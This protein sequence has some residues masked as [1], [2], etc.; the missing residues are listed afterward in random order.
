MGDYGGMGGAS[1]FHAARQR[2]LGALST[3]KSYEF[4]MSWFIGL[5]L[6][7]VV[8]VV[9]AGYLAGYF[10][11]PTSSFNPAFEATLTGDDGG[12]GGATLVQRIEANSLKGDG[13]RRVRIT[14]RASSTQD[15]RIDSIWISQP[16]ST[17]DPYD[18]SDDLTFFYGKAIVPANMS[19]T[20]PDTGPGV[21]YNFETA[22]SPGLLIAVDFE[23]G[24]AS[25]I[26]F[27]DAQPQEARAYR[28][29]WSEAGK[30]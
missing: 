17:G 6:V 29:P 1:S 26:R 2:G 11:Q 3:Q 9:V 20:L 27:R 4:L 28:L 5:A 30:E 14:L 23:R 25:G 8:A 12:W 13:G 18:A 22:V 19:R 10:N 16:N 7:A 21:N 24:T 15:A